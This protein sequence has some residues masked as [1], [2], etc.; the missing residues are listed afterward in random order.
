MKNTEK[1]KVNVKSIFKP[2]T[3]AI[4]IIIAFAFFVLLCIAFIQYSFLESDYCLM[5]AEKSFKNPFP[6][7]VFVTEEERRVIGP[8]NLI[9]PSNMM[10]PIFK[11]QLLCEGENKFLGFF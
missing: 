6:K 5:I 4:S 8:T 1:Q 10:N 7:Y 11:E 9:P 2:I 3:A